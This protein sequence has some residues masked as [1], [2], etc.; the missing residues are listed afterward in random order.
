M[1][2]R[3]KIVYLL[4]KSDVG[5]AQKYVADLLAGLPKD[6]FDAEVWHG[7]KEVRFL[8]NVFWPFLLFINDWLA[9]VEL[10]LK[11]KSLKPDIVHLNSSKAGVIGALAAKLAGVK[12]VVFT[13]HGWV[14]QPQN[15]VNRSARNFYLWLHK[16]AALFQDKIINVSNYDLA[17]AKDSKIAP[18]N[19]LVVIHNGLNYQKINFLDRAV[20]RKF[21]SQKLATNFSEKDFLVGSIGRLVKEKDYSTLIKSAEQLKGSN[22]KFIVIGDGYELNKLIDLIK[23]LNLSNKFYL[24]GP[25]TNAAEYLRAFDLFI[26]SSV[27]E[28]LPYVALEAMAAKLPLVLTTVGGLPELIPDNLKDLCLSPARQPDSLA[29]KIEAIFQKPLD[30]RFQIGQYF[31]DHLARNFSFKAMLDKTIDIYLD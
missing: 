14:F 10:S 7:G 24:L 11:F 1:E 27:K 18:E 28:G 5:G 12:K 16:L 3:K 29:Q 30:Q 25:L 19:K 9:L 2:K 6:Q 23:K 20:A 8:S 22:R 15:E 21:L 17:I 13:A 4:T 31:F 26:M